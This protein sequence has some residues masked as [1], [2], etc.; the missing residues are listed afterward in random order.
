MRQPAQKHGPSFPI[1]FR[2]LLVTLVLAG[3][4][5]PPLSAQDGEPEQ[6]QSP[7][8]SISL[9]LPDGTLVECTLAN[10]GSG[11]FQIL[12]S[13]TLPNFKPQPTKTSN[14]PAFIT[15]GTF[16]TVLFIF[17]LLAQITFTARFVV[18][19]LAS[20]KA[21]KSV[22]PVAFWWLS[23][24][25]GTSL[26]IYFILRHEPVGILGQAT[27]WFV[28]ARNLYLIYRKPID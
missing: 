8:E 23:I 15:E 26:L 1:T 2:L 5:T 13:E 17:G 14:T 24:S 27:G 28:Y 10:D 7:S 3:T 25:G 4:V 19:W 11:E 22:I 9:R 21:K 20:E 18:Q 16:G 6:I 12:N